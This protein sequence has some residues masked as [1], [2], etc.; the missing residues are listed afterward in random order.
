MPLSQNRA[1]T[2][3]QHRPITTMKISTFLTDGNTLLVVLCM[4]PW[5]PFGHSEMGQRLRH[6]QQNH[7]PVGDATLRGT[8]NHVIDHEKVHSNATYDAS[9]GV[10]VNDLDQDGAARPQPRIIGGSTSEPDEFPYYVALEG[11]GASLIAPGVVLSA[12]HCAPNGNEYENKSVRVG[13]YLLSGIWDSNDVDRVVAEQK[14]HPSFNQKTVENDFMLLRLQQPVYLADGGVT[15]E[16]SNDDIDIQDGTELTVMGL[17]VTSYSFLGGLGF[18]FGRPA[19]PDK[20]MDVQIEAYSDERCIDAYGSGWNGVKTNSM[21][22]AGAPLGGKD[23][24]QGDS[25]G[26]LVKRTSSGVHKQVGVVSWGVGCGDRNYP[27]VYSRIPQYGY[28]WIKSVVCDEWGEDASFCDDTSEPIQDPAVDPPIDDPTPT[29]SPAQ[30]EP[31]DNCVTVIF[32]TW[33]W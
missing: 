10:S 18:G 22:C 31:D 11:C 1:R 14:N 9:F 3:N 15:L 33:C 16:L 25:G 6:R 5:A 20:L 4:L 8:N 28:D 30:D 32:W 19:Q 7:M 23:S 17:G 12:A 13:A 24:C 29:N 2:V 21:F 26:P 27:G